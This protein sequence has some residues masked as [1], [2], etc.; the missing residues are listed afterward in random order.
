MLT[1]LFGVF[2]GPFSV[3]SVWNFRCLTFGNRLEMDLPTNSEQVRHEI[4]VKNAIEIRRI[5]L[6]FCKETQ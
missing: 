4:A 2:A 3:P 1:V 6:T 5:P